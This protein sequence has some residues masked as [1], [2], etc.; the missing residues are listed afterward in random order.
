M[1]YAFPTITHIDDVLPA[2]KDSP[3][4]IVVEKD[5]YKV[6][7]YVV[8]TDE[9][10]PSIGAD[11]SHSIIRR[12]C[13]G[14]VFDQNTGEIINRR[15]HKFFNISEREETSIENIDW[16]KPHC[17]LEKLDGS[18]VSPCLIG[19]GK[20]DLRWMTKMGITDTSMAA[21]V[22]VASRPNYAS[23]ASMLLFS[24]FTPIFEWCSNNN[25]I[26]LDYPEDQL[27]LLAI[28]NTQTGEYVPYEYLKAASQDANIPLVKSYDVAG[29]SDINQIIEMVHN[30]EDSEGIVVRFDDGHMV[31]CKSAW[32][33]RIHKVKS[34]LSQER[35]V[36]RIILNNELDD[37]IPILPP[38]DLKRIETFRDRILSEI[39]LSSWA[40][41]HDIEHLREHDVS[42][43]EFA[44]NNFNEA[45]VLKSLYFTLWDEK[46][47][48]TSVVYDNIVKMILKNST[49]TKNY[50]RVKEEFFGGV[51]YENG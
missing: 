29:A 31:K 20:R 34:M 49:N 16:S 6:I 14:L 33:I 28:R 42:R 36:V 27:Y 9:T 41:A 48:D 19:K 39:K 37:L 32:Y 5:S 23:F 12:E 38:D 50:Q 2:I 15:F 13:R 30:A 26:V 1:N 11:D 4:F 3:E 24:G 47:V 46:D 25:R 17:I 40:V 22:F 51:H 8:M 7:N 45:P 10:F 35:D 21:E 18:M 43:K 44:L